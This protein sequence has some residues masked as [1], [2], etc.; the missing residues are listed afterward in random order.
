MTTIEKLRSHRI[1]PFAVFDFVATYV[2]VWY[3]A[4]HLKLPRK[5]A[6]WLAI[7]AGIIVHELLGLKTPLNKMVVGPGTNILA[8]A[9]IAF[10][11]F[12]GVK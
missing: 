11:I 3:G 7:P 8:Q 1:G 5:R 6:M 10:M 9:V 12:K 4:P 2:A